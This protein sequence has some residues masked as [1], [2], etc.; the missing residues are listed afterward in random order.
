MTVTMKP[1]PSARR[2]AAAAPAAAHA[3]RTRP[4]WKLIPSASPGREAP[5]P[6]RVQASCAGCT[7]CFSNENIPDVVAARRPRRCR[8]SSEGG[9]PVERGEPRTRRRAERAAPE[10]PPAVT[11]AP[12]RPGEVRGGERDDEERRQVVRDDDPGGRDGDQRGAGPSSALGGEVHAEEQ[13]GEQGE[14]RELRQRAA[15]VEV[16]EV[17]RREQVQ[18]AGDE[19]AARSEPPSRPGV[20]SQR[21]HEER[22]QQED[23]ER[24]EQRHAGREEV[25]CGQVE[26][27]RVEVRERRALAAV[28]EGEPARIRGPAPDLVGERDDA[29]ERGGALVRLEPPACEERRPRDPGEHGER[30]E[31]GDVASGT[32]REAAQPLG[33]EPGHRR[34]PIAPRSDSAC[35]RYRCAPAASP[36]ASHARARLTVAS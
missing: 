2:N 5:W 30:R 33:G 18:R 28:A 9:Q 4:S 35:A 26:P 31:R 10:R 14:R 7:K 22:R 15:D 11:G 16:H 1:R 27:G 36:S 25:G 17:V 12:R 13:P 32:R 20:S 19:P 21:P 3:R 29:L 24:E 8:W 34:P 23:L 6:H